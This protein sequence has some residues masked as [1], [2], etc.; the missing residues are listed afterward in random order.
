MPPSTN[1]PNRLVITNVLSDTGSTYGAVPAPAGL[2][3]AV[4]CTDESLATPRR[5]TVA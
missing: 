4:K 1:D 2:T 5:D 3:A